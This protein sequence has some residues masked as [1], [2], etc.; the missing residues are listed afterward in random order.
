MS[1]INQKLGS[2]VNWGSQVE[3]NEETISKAVNKAE[4]P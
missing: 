3:F 4:G 1:S 2:V